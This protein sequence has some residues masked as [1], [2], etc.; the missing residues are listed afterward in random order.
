MVERMT[1]AARLLRFLDASSVVCHA[2][3][4]NCMKSRKV[5]LPGK[6][7]CTSRA[8][9]SEGFK[10]AMTLTCSDAR[11]S[12]RGAVC[13]WRGEFICYTNFM[14][15]VGICNEEIIFLKR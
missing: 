14:W 10:S 13:P 6:M 9:N 3:A 11:C 8:E 12:K 4:E 15:H 5:R 1:R 7:T 2:I